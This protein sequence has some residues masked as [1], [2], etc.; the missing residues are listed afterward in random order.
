MVWSRG[1][2]AIKLKSVKFIYIY[3]SFAYIYILD[4]FIFF[5]FITGHVIIKVLKAKDEL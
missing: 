2:I 3:I 1:I 4:L 5:D